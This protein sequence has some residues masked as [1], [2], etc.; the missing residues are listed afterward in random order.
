MS[1]Y[2]IADLHGDMNCF[3]EILSN[4]H[5]SDTCYVL[6][7]CNDRGP[8]KDSINI[9]TKI[10]TD[11][12]FIYLAGNHEIMLYNSV[13]SYLS[14]RDVYQPDVMRHFQNG[15][16]DT[17]LYVLKNV[18]YPL[19]FVKFLKNLPKT[20][21]YTN[22]DGKVILMSHAGYSPTIDGECKASEQD[23]LWDREHFNDSWRTYDNYIVVHGHTP[24]RYMPKSANPY[25]QEIGALWYCKRHKVNIDNCTYQSGVAVMLNL[26]TFE[27]IMVGAI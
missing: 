5:D 25:N 6:G 11:K 10:L 26:D 21:K 1:T 22:S 15:G 19:K 9:I 7:D 2:A 13:E 23:L 4:L 20:A 27:E 24:M 14:L 17:L 8:G 12:R 3:K 18:K 16:K